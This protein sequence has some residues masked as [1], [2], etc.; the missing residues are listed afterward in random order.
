MPVAVKDA[1]NAIPATFAL[2]FLDRETHYAHRIGAAPNDRDI[3]GTE[4]VG[5]AQSFEV[6]DFGAFAFANNKD[7]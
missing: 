2:C 5:S 3:G 7:S 6:F 4:P 1:I